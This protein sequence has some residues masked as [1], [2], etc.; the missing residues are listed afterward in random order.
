MM[1]TNCGYDWLQHQWYQAETPSPLLLPLEKL[2]FQAVKVRRRAYARGLR[3]T[4]RLPV[5]VIVIG[6][7]TVGGV[8]KTPLVI[9][10]AHALSARGLKPGIISRGHGG[11]ATALPLRV[12]PDSDPLEAGDE[13]VLIAQKTGCP[14]VVAKKRVLAG[15]HLL[16]VTDCDVVIADDGL[17]HYALERDVEIAVI[18]GFRPVG[19]GHLLPAGPLREPPQRLSEVDRILYA[20]TGPEGE[21]IMTLQGEVAVNLADPRNRRPLRDFQGQPCYAMAGIGHPAR[22]FDYLETLGLQPETRAYPDHCIYGPHDLNRPEDWPV[23]MTE[24]DAVKCTRF[25]DSR[26]WSVPVEAVLPPGTADS[27][28]QLISGKKHNGRKTA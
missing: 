7:I 6:N 5:P 15:Q 23:F 12:Y 4:V 20:G 26:C 16:A 22:F 27:L 9:W 17:Q 1:I 18:D 2:F 21:I 25:A 11:R 13:P 28:H 3:K 19:N 10:L 8:G 24:K 14:V